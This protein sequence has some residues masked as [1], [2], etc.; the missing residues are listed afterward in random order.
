MTHIRRTGVMTGVAALLLT[1]TACSGLGRSTVGMLSFRAHDSPIEVSYSNTSVRGCQ[2]I[3]L[4]HGAAHVENNTLVDV[5]LYRT[6]DCRKGDREDGTY[7]ATSL[8]DVTAPASLP[9]RSFRVI[10]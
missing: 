10:H 8:S 5:V 9:W 6:E 7:V 3:G 1:A 2:S 4:P